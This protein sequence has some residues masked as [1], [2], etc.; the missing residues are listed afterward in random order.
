[1]AERERIKCQLGIEVNFV[2]WALKK[3][4]GCGLRFRPYLHH[5]EKLERK[6]G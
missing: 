2:R 1:M 3:V 6:Y 4:A 5:E